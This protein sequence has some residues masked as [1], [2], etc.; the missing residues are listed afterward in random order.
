MR[1]L[2]QTGGSGGLRTLGTER[3][4]VQ[5]VRAGRGVQVAGLVSGVVRHGL[6]GSGRGASGGGE[7]SSGNRWPRDGRSCGVGCLRW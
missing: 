4:E 2:L 5:F 7:G 1:V 6:T 3:R